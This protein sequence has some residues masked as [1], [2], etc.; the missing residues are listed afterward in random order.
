MKEVVRQHAIKT[1]EKTRERKFQEYEELMT[2]A[3]DVE[4]GNCN[5]IPYAAQKYVDARKIKQDMEVILRTISDLN[6][7]IQALKNGKFKKL[8]LTCIGNCHSRKFN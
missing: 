8:E 6:T 2:I 4:L 7:I 1:L 3:D 5:Y